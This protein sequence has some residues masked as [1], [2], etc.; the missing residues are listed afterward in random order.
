[1]NARRVAQ[2]NQ[3]HLI[4]LMSD[5]DSAATPRHKGRSQNRA[6]VLKKLNMAHDPTALG[7]Q[8]EGHP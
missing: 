6:S 5:D 2:L 7:A 3:L 8:V 1:M 4:K